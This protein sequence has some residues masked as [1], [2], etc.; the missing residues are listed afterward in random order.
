MPYGNHWNVSTNL[1]R[2][3]C[4]NVSIQELNRINIWVENIRAVMLNAQFLYFLFEHKKRVQFTMVTQQAGTLSLYTL[5]KQFHYW[6]VLFSV[7]IKER[8]FSRNFLIW[9]Q[10]VESAEN[11]SL[12]ELRSVQHRLHRR[13]AFSY[14][15]LNP[16]PVAFIFQSNLKWIW[17]Q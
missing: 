3:I 15:K 8:K 12:Y 16:L 7:W 2:F 17:I 4:P 6:T 1:F 9:L 10:K 14:V 5:I 11:S 13:L